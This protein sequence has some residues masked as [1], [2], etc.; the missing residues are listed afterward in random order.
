MQRGQPNAFSAP[1]AVFHGLRLPEE[2]S[3]AGYAAIIDA[4]ALRVPLP[5]RLCA[6]GSKHKVYTEGRW[7]LFTPRHAP[8]P[9]LGAHLTF[10]L[11]Y[12]GLDLAVLYCL[13]REIAEAELVSMVRASPTGAYARRLWFLYDGS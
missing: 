12:E 2:A 10:A 7:K 11:K 8:S 1:V 9:S 3:P 5:R 4:Y 6:I 13:F